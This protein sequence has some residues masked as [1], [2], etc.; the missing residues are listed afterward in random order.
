MTA[1]ALADVEAHAR[2]CA[3][4]EQLLALGVAVREHSRSA[5]RAPV[6]AAA[7]ETLA[8]GTLVGR[9]TV[10]ELLG[11][12]GMGDVY[13]AYDSQLD[14]KVA[15][16]IL[17]VRVDDEDGRGEARLLREARAIARLSHRN[18]IAVHDGGRF[19]KR[20]FIAMEYVEGQ[21]LSAWLRAKDRS[22]AE[23]LAIFVEA[24]HGLAAAH[25][26]GLVHRDFKPHNV[27]VG[28]DGAVRVTDFGLVRNVDGLSV[29]PDP[30]PRPDKTGD[31]SLTKTGE[32]I[33][34]PLYMSPEQFRRGP[35]D[36]RSDQFSYCVAL[37]EALY[38]EHPFSTGGPLADLIS[39]VVG[40]RVRRA[41]DRSPVP[42]R[43]RRILLR[44][45]SVNPAERWP[46]MTAL[47]AA[48]VADPTRARRRVIAAVVVAMGM[49][50]VAV[51]LG[52]ASRP[53]RTLG[54]CQ[55][56]VSR[57]AGVWLP[58]SGASDGDVRRASLTAAFTAVTGPDVGRRWTRTV[59]TLDRFATD[60]LAMYR[61]ACEATHVRG[62]QSAEVLDARMTC[63]DERREALKALT[64]LLSIADESVL[65][66]A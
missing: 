20:V 15:L 21:T 54:F 57:L 55:T 10:L 45:L 40:G 56:G 8:R 1:S 59:A 66:R 36:S 19:G 41:P 26:A 12:G 63:L 27:M 9:Y 32:L 60:W 34:T 18:V 50:G 35:T 13:A 3:T 64:D 2:T 17:R 25:A 24:A 30:G 38:G 44:G 62:E 31:P 37:Y 33:G 5:A 28:H 7:D 58:P 48:L 29:T 4:C 14:R 46:S 61:D 6:L 53:A 47:A 16:K 52:R 23:I 49:V 43:L 22:Q 42:L 51:G 39:A 11:R 65:D